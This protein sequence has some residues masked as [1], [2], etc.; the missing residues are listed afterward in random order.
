MIELRFEETLY[1]GFAIDEAAKTFEPFATIDR[2]R[3]GGAFILR[4]TLAESA[5]ADGHAEA[6]V[7]AELAN[8]ALGKTIER[9]GAAP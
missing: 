3:E 2:E 5:A 4:V 1:D 6:D 9:R 7:A 8:H